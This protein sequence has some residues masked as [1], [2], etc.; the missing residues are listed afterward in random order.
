MM[1]QGSQNPADQDLQSAPT[2]IASRSN[3]VFSWL[4]RPCGGAAGYVGSVVSQLVGAS[5]DEPQAAAEC[6]D[7]L[8]GEASWGSR[9]AG[10]AH[11][12]ISCT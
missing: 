2:S 4:H 5:S 12:A 1:R 6:D 8:G 3:L 9:Q 10:D 7:S 11:I